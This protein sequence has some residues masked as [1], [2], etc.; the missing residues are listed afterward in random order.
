MAYTTI[1]KS[2]NFQD[3]TIWDGNNS[4]PT[5]ISGL[6]Y[7][8]DMVWAKARTGTY[9]TQDHCVND[10]V[11]GANNLFRMGKN[12]A[13]E[14]DDNNLLSFTSDG[15][16]MGND[17]KINQASTTYCGWSWKA[18]TTSGLSGG[19]ITPSAYS[20]NTTSKF[21]IY[22]YTG[23]GSNG[24][25]AHGL[26]TTPKMIWVKQTSGSENWR[27]YHE[28]LGDA[29][30]YM[31]LNGSGSVSTAA[32]VWNSTAPTSTLFSIGTDGGVNTSSST[33][34]AYV[35]GDVSGFSKFGSY[36]GNG[37]ADGTFIYTGF[38]PAFILL[39][40]SAT[41]S[42]WYI[43][44]NKRP[45]YY[46]PNATVLFA[47][48]TTAESTN[49]SS[50]EHPIDFLSNGFKIR[51]TSSA[52]NGSGNTVIYMACAEAPLVGTNNIPATAR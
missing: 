45:S 43:Y 26:G 51:T 48:T 14:T 22:K 12:N 39:K 40:N 21:G 32:S 37:N 30:K 2:I 33:Y 29:T 7:Q 5:T 41:S 11:R 10:S 49:T 38:K 44:D 25:I 46:N 31:T 52:R 8:P 20:I 18:G 9:E 23:T 27:V 47:E 17:G 1:N 19:T 50:S 6:S 35:W 3:T 4:D 24:T 16:T 15:W 42:S 13:E 36:T 34:I 28:G